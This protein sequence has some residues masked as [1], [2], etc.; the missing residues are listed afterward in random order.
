M[1][2]EVHAKI[3]NMYGDYVIVSAKVTIAEAPSTWSEVIETALFEDDFPRLD[4]LTQIV[5]SYC[6][7]PENPLICRN[8]N[9][10]VVD[11]KY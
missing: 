11:C 2:D 8:E 10:L 4:D 9:D 1:V 3:S 6:S 7:R 5:K